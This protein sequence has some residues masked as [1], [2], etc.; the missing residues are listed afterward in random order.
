MPT[1]SRK[2]YS[3]AQKLVNYFPCGECF[4]CRRKK[5]E[6]LMVRAYFEDC[7]YVLFD[8][9]T[10]SEKC[11]PWLKSVLYRQFHQ[12]KIDS[13]VG[14]QNKDFILSFDD[15]R[16]IYYPDFQKF[17]KRLRKYFDTDNEIKY[18]VSA[19]YG[20]EEGRTHRPHFHCIFFCNLDIEPK[21]L[22]RKIKKCWKF[23]I[24]DGWQ[25]KGIDYFLN[26][27]VFNGYDA[28]YKVIGYLCKYVTK[29]SEYERIVKDTLNKAMRQI[30]AQL[31]R[32]HSTDLEREQ[33][34]KLIKSHKQ[35][36][37]W[38]KGFGKSFLTDK[39]I[40]E[41]ESKLYVQIRTDLRNKK[42]SLPLYY[43]RKIYNEI[44]KST[45]EVRLNERGLK[46]LPKKLRSE[47]YNNIKRMQL[48]NDSDVSNETLAYYLTYVKDR[49]EGDFLPNY[50]EVVA[51]NFNSLL[52]RKTF[53]KGNVIKDDKIYSTEQFIENSV[54]N[55]PEYD[56]I[57]ENIFKVE[58]D[59]KAKVS[60]IQE[61][62][63]NLKKN[64][65]KCL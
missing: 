55:Y 47:Y 9:L 4:E 11:V 32:G 2:I 7:K 38:S 60:A 52:D 56:E 19:E 13:L 37:K 18:I 33:V 25:D 53:P 27:R 65:K 54:K 21:E 62:N 24:T 3:H 45:K 10:Y 5:T 29:E 64:C 22:S 30:Y 34:S 57:L 50:N 1:N 61:Y 17:M 23:G 31:Y 59:K 20:T 36:V 42:Y 12:Y 49:K 28:K 58:S 40:E 15:I 41:F 14:V 26:N 8:T 63:Y 44:D 51:L 43:R 39:N 46:L 6:D 35:F 16:I 48:Y